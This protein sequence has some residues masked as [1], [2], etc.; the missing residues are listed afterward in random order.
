MALYRDQAI[1]LRR[2]D[3]SETSQ[4]LLV[5]CRTLGPQRLIAKGIKRGTKSRF[6]VGVDLLEAGVVNFSRRDGGAA[7]LATMTEWT[8]SD[9]NAHLRRDLASLH[10]ALYGAEVTGQLMEE[11]DPHPELYDAFAAFLADHPH[12]EPLARLVVY[13][14][15]LLHHIGLWPRLD[16]CAGCGRDIGSDELTYFSSHQGGLLCR[17]CEPAAVEK[18]RVS[19]ETV[20]ALRWATS[21][22]PPPPGRDAPD[23]IRSA[24]DLLDYH[25]SELMSRPPR[26]SRPLRVVLGA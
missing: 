6:A 13:L 10:V 14:P 22:S 8:Q 17:E 4:V 12:D 23:A 11:G 18:R 3:Y 20:E 24:F 5:F 25:L 26:L 15:T 19:H 1:V 9:L 2:L 7:H 16:A 21:D